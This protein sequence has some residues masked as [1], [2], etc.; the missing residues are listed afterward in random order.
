M[1][2]L[3]MVIFN[4][5]F[6]CTLI[7]MDFQ[8]KIFVSVLYAKYGDYVTSKSNESP[9]QSP[10]SNNLNTYKELSQKLEDIEENI[11]GIYKMIM[12]H[13]GTIASNKNNDRLYVVIL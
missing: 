12:R 6:R 3:I 8:T 13:A 11:M 7:A 4:T 1:C 2:I 9:T 5:K 10:T